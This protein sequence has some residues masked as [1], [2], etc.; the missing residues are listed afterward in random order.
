MP[1]SVCP[2]CQHNNPADSQECANCH[3]PV[4]R[5]D[6]AET[7]M[8][9]DGWSVAIPQ[10]SAAG[11]LSALGPGRI[12]GERYEILA[13][14][15][16]GG[17]GAV[18]KARDRE[19]DRIVALKVIRPDLVGHPTALH[20]FKQELIL[21]RQ[22]T[23]KN[24]IRIF[25][26]GTAD[27]LKYIT[28]EFIEGRDLSG[29]LERG[30]F[31]PEEAVRVMRQVCR[32]LDAAHSEGVVHRDLKPQN[33]MMDASGKVSVMDFGLARSV[34]MTAFTQTGAMLG[35]PAYMSPEQAKGLP[36]DAR[37]DLFAFGII[38]YELLNGKAPFQSDTVYGCLLRRTQEPAP[39]LHENDPNIPQPISEVVRKCLATDPANRYQ[40]ATEILADL[41]AI[42]GGRSMLSMTNAGASIA[43][44]PAALPPVPAV[45]P[46]RRSFRKWVTAGAGT[47][48]VAG[49]V[50][51]YLFRD[52]FAPAPPPAT[53]GKAVSLLVADFSNATG[54]SNF[55][56]ALEPMF[57]VALEGA[58]FVNAFSRGEARRLAKQLPNGSER[59]DETTARL[60]A[61]GQGVNVVIT[62]SLVREGQGYGVSVKA[63]DALSGK[64]LETAKVSAPK[65]DEVLLAIPKL[66]APIRRALGDKTP[67]SAQITAA[68]GAFRSASLEAVHE[69]GV[70]MELQLAGKMDDALKA[71]TKASQLDPTFARAYTGMAAT[72]RNLGQ[73]DE[74]AK[75]FGLANEHMD[76]MTQRERYR[77]RGAYFVSIGDHKS[78]VEEYGELLKQFP[79]DN[80][81]HINLASCYSHLRNMPKAVDEAKI[82]V[83]LTPKSA[84]HHMNLSLFASYAGEFA[85]AAREALAAQEINP[86]YEKG[87]L[88][89]A[90][91]QTG[92]E[93]W[94]DAAASYQKL[95]SLSPLGASMGAAGLAD[96]ALYQGR[97]TEAA[98]RLE[99]A[100]AADID[101][102]IANR[103]AERYAALA[104]VQLMR[105]QNASAIAAAGK[106]LSNGRRASIRF[107]AA[108][109][110]IEAGDVAKGRAL[111]SEL[112]QEL[113]LESRAFG[114][115]LEGAA[116]L[117][118]KD[119]AKAIQILS[120][121][122]G[123]LDTWMGRFYLGRAYLEAGHFPQADS[124]FDRCLRRRGE[125][126]ELGDWPSYGYLPIV[127]YY[128]GRVREGMKSP[129]FAEAYKQYLEIRGAAN[130]DPLLPD[131]RRRA[132][133]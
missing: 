4:T 85:L 10:E 113:Q 41:D 20:R 128:Q 116:A 27:G 56:A 101:L 126:I 70:G 15:G 2:H 83:E 71:F 61:V 64:T 92:Q 95:A 53:G 6:D 66:A 72:L 65:R 45:A 11:D 51:A 104:Y 3:R 13:M 39:V 125:I 82:A 8:I 108:H 52:R 93:Q 107:L 23:H 127:Y 98:K 117:K 80:A 60:V 38:F 35:T 1:A 91:A 34:E 49:G 22:I 48:A 118:Q 33:I 28:M 68:A 36:A 77:T 106:A 112:G 16:R 63:L 79:A 89:M 87:F 21:S 42:A 99:D 40:S 88:T 132:G 9:G 43:P 119:P 115:V 94:K 37:S 62:G 69:Y 100:A 47:L 97:F 133:A 57:N 110:L 24:V 31:E 12:I 30:K 74:A 54:D 5:F 111:A 75:Y 17:M 7:Q 81:G 58:S 109:V 32:A 44:I 78:C 131:V 114:R 130:E 96:L 59:L 123:M 73:R 90:Y 55:D 105:G 103:A 84:V 46:A 29:H 26:L 50:S 86:K 14:L 18:Y 124:E 121:A 120:D 76:Q 122:N 67:E 25:D 102:K 129:G 19:V